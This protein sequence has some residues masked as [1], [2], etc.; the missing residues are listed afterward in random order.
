MSIRS[1]LIFG[2][3][4]LIMGAIDLAFCIVVGREER[5]EEEEKDD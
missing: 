3:F 5:R 2:A 4:M 1:W